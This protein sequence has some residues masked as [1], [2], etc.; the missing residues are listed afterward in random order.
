MTGA[1]KTARR[2]A[3]A[4]QKEKEDAAKCKIVYFQAFENAGGGGGATI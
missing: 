2:E 4:F 3:R 1:R